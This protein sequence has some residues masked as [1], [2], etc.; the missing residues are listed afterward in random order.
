MN[1]RKELSIEELLLENEALRAENKAARERIAALRAE[2]DRIASLEEKVRERLARD[3][4]DGPAQLLSAIIMSAQF[5]RQILTR[6]PEKLDKLRE[7][8]DQLESLTVKA[9]HQTQTMLFDLRPVTLETQGLGPALES[10]VK[11]LRLADDFAVS[12]EAKDFPERLDAKTEAAIFSIVREAVSNA[13]KHA[14][15]SH[16]ELGMAKQDG[17]L[18]ITI[19][20][21]GQGFDPARVDISRNGFESPGLLSMRESADMLNGEFSIESAVGQ[22]TLVKLIVPLQTNDEAKL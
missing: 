2:K 13:R 12:L 9:I 10:Y 8:L 18:V 6:T 7:E 11:R 22:G 1:E 20:D 5:A 4:H 21:D 14:H 3:L 16:L 15:A 17:R 19:R